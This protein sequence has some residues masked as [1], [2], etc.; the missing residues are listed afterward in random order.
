MSPT[1]WHK[2]FFSNYFSGGSGDGFEA[3]YYIDDITVSDTDPDQ[4]SYS[5]G[6]SVSGLTGTVI[7]ALG[8]SHSENHWIYSNGAY[9]FSQAFTAG[10]TYA[11]TVYTQPEGQT[12]TVANGSGTISSS[13]V[14]NVTYL[15]HQRVFINTVHLKNRHFKRKTEVML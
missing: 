9:S 2:I 11:V 14:T 5:V 1:S 6:G 13:N 8:G 15:L 12:C 3:D 10:D 4:G 7:L